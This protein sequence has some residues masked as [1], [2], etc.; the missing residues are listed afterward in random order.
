MTRSVLG[1]RS[2]Q[3]EVA[4]YDGALPATRVSAAWLPG[5]AAGRI[6]DI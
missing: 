1:V 5:T 6:S 4:I 3:V 2:I